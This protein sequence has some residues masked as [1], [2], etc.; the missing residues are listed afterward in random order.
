MY[1]KL[2]KYYTTPLRVIPLNEFAMYA[3]LDKYYTSTQVA[4]KKTRLLCMLN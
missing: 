2:D 3:K 4:R 1:A